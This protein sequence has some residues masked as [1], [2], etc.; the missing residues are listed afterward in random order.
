MGKIDYESSD[1]RSI[2]AFNQAEFELEGLE[3]LEGKSLAERFF[4]VRDAILGSFRDIRGES[5]SQLVRDG[6]VKG[7]PQSESVPYLIG[8]LY[9]FV[10]LEHSRISLITDPAIRSQEGYRLA[11]ISYLFGIEIHQA[12][13]AN[14]QTNKLISLSYIH[15]F[16]PEY[17]DNFIP[18]KYTEENNH[19]DI[20]AYNYQYDKLKPY[21]I[22]EQMSE[23][24]REIYLRL[25]K[26][27]EIEEE[28]MQLAIG[29][30]EMREF[31]LQRIGDLDELLKI[32]DIKLTD[33]EG[34]QRFKYFPA[35]VLET[36][37]ANILNTRYPGYI[38]SKFPTIGEIKQS[39]IHN[40]L[41]TEEGKEFLRSYING[42]IDQS[43]LSGSQ[44]TKFFQYALQNLQF[45]D[46]EFRRVLGLETRE[47]HINEYIRRSF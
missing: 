33:L 12:A 32:C 39:F 9:R 30:N 36:R 4:T 10:D 37:I 20:K 7:Y 41:G 34:D 46:N 11:Q 8:D 16:C 13:D 14:G 40:L 45:L 2:R 3:K 15:E 6:D 18:I 1:S 44:R 28:A 5:V 22:P 25:I 47:K 29:P 17:R 21:P 24:D 38:F 27:R 19:N 23:R 43:L 26:I 35:M 31:D 42:T